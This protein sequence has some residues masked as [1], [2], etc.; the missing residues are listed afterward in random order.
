MYSNPGN[1]QSLYK[2]LF[3]Y[4]GRTAKDFTK[5]VRE[6]STKDQGCSRDKNAAYG[7]TTHLV[8]DLMKTFLD[9]AGQTNSVEDIC[10]GFQSGIAG[11][12][13]CLDRVAT[14]GSSHLKRA[15]SSWYQCVLG[16]LTDCHAA[17]SGG[18]AWTRPLSVKSPRFLRS[19]FLSTQPGVGASVLQRGCLPRAQWGRP[20]GHTKANPRR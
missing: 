11:L 6:A 12:N 20:S 9:P 1:E 7:F 14:T 15:C 17:I 19:Q 18:G 8:E 3:P 16:A 13:E 2:L 10:S 4:T 5:A